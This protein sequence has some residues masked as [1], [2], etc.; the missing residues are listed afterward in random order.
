MNNFI[1]Q[2]LFD[3]QTVLGQIAAAEL[4]PIVH[5]LHLARL[6]GR[7]V[8][9][10][11]NGGSAATASHWANDLCKATIAPGVP[12]LR[13]IAL[14]D[15]VPLITAW[16][17]DTAYENIFSEQLANLLRQ[18]DIVIGI[19][20]SGNSPNVLNAMR[21][22]RGLGAQTIGI[23]GFQ[24]GYLKDLVDLCYVV[25]SNSMA[26]IEDIHM[27]LTHAISSTL[28]K[29]AEEALQLRQERRHARAVFIDRDGVINR[30]RSDYVKS[31]E[32]FEF[33]GGTL[34]A[35]ARLANTNLG[36]AI[37]S[38]Q[39]AI[40]RNLVTCETIED[41]HR[42]MLLA[43]EQAGGHVDHIA[44]CPHR[45]DEQCACR[46][47]RPG[48]LIE[49]GRRLDVDLTKSYLIGDSVGDIQA[50][51]AVGCTTLLVRTGL[52]QEASAGLSR[53]DGHLPVVVDDFSAAVDWI[54]THESKLEARATEPAEPV[55]AP[56]VTLLRGCEA[57]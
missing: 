18:G 33:L 19:S 54:L 27:V 56:C 17:N 49:S 45:P 43:I 15:N 25:P 13:A 12:R 28:R 7:I 46:K 55:P 39:S 29:R 51:M 6:E 57:A 37:I 34:G 21:Y 2:Y 24:G 41:I 36:V 48:L 31:W 32:E 8:F 1:T 40:G 47:P 20:G 30:N 23:T 4:E 16:G 52:G 53:L 35:L 14:T 5:A 38:N 44:Y 9:L 22:A 42:R 10:L 50:G 26:Q 3:V 11:G